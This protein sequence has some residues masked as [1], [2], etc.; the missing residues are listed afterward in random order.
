MKVEVVNGN[1]V[2]TLPI[3]SAL[4]LS[5]SQKT[6]VAATTG[7]FKTSEAT[8]NGLPISVS[9]NCTVPKAA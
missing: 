3:N 5:A 6:R 9:V 8:I 2:I 4:P 7:G 1:I